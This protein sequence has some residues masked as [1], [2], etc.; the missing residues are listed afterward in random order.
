MKIK[1]IEN[2]PE[3]D[4]AFCMTKNELKA[5]RKLI[6]VFGVRDWTKRGVAQDHAELGQPIYDVMD[7]YLY[8]E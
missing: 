6:G 7:N 3:E 5:L 2:S 8:S 1:K 4:V